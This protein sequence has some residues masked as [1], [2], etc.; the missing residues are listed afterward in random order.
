MSYIIF[1]NLVDM[2]TTGTPNSGYIVAYD[3]DGVLK[4]KDIYGTVSPIGG[5]GGSGITSVV[6]DNASGIE[7][8]VGL[9]NSTVNTSYNTLLDPS[10]AM[11]SGVGGIPSGT[12]AGS[13]YGKNMVELFDDLLFPTVNPT[14]TIPTITVSSTITGIREIGLTISPVVTLT[15]VENDASIFTQLVIRKNINSIGNV[16]IATVSSTASMTVTTTTSIASQFGYSDPNN[17]NLSF[18]I[19]ATESGFSMPAPV[20]G[21]SSTV[22]YSGTGDYNAGLPKNTNKGTTHT[23]TPAIRLTTSP[24][25]ASTG[26]ASSNQTITGY[27]PYFYGKTSIQQTASQIKAIIESGGGTKVVND[28]SGGLSMAFNASSEWPWFA[29]YNVYSTKT[30]WYENALNNGN[31]GGVTDL[32][33]SP[34][35]L[36]VTSP[37]GYWV[38]IYK[39]YPANKVTTLGTATIS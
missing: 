7:V 38:V 26:F 3:L 6:T 36:T 35:S 5:S 11:I 13:L 29:T 32:F 20:S 2:T 9:T 31:I 28:A 39:I 8:L 23:A 24:Q 1:N 4:Q 37:N 27:Y 14:Y 30:T 17:P 34:T 16:N 22:V 33:A 25:A 21:G 10:L 15:G 19:T 12:T 18:S